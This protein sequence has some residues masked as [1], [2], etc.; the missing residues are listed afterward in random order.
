MYNLCYYLIYQ[1]VFFV[2]FS[3]NVGS[4]NSRAHLPLTILHKISILTTLPGSAQLKIICHAT[5]NPI[6]LAA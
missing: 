1:W 2:F 4:Y 6:V 5:A 3:N